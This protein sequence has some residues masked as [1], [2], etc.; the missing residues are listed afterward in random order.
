M[1]LLFQKFR[2]SSFTILLLLFALP[3][4]MMAQ[5]KS[6]SGIVKNSKG[7]PVPNV[8]VLVK[9]TEVGTSTTANGSFTINAAP[10]ATLLLTAVNFEPAEIKIGASST[11]TVVLTDKQTLLTDVVVVGYGRSSRKNLSSA[12]ATV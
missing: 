10:D 11:Y 2:K 5:T 8:S 3:L 1:H 7:D 6:V 12:V 4:S 9:G